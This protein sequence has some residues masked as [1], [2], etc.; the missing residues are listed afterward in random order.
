MY[1]VKVRVRVRVTIK[2][3]VPPGTGPSSL[4]GGRSWGILT[5]YAVQKS[6]EISS[7]C[8]I[9]IISSPTRIQELTRNSPR[10]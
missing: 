7:F 9:G 3:A 1:A 6:A 8:W 4:E 5:P 2:F 10:L